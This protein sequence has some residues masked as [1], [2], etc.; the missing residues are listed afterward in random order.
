MAGTL[1]A[2]WERGSISLVV[3]KNRQGDWTAEAFQA[4]T[5]FSEEA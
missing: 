2:T 4:L 5:T 3:R 1:E